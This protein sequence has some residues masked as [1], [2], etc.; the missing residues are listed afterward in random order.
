LKPNI[1]EAKGRFTIF[2]S[3]LSEYGILGFDYGYAL[4]SPKTLTIWEAQFGDFSN[5]G[6]IN[7]R[8]VYFGSRRQM[9]HAKQEVAQERRNAIKW[10]S[11]WF[12]IRNCLRQ[13]KKTS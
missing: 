10:L 6:Q 13:T 9:E 8:S 2:N 1:K 5:G 7:D 3:S 11:Q 12:L 4:A